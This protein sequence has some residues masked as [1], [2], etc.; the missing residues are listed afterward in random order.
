MEKQELEIYLN[1]LTNVQ[2]EQYVINKYGKRWMLVTILPEELQRCPL[3]SDEEIKESL[4]QGEEDYERS[5]MCNS[6]RWD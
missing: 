5:E 4:R 1:L 2:F 3:L 6:Q